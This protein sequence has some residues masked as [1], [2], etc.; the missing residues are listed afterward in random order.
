MECREE[1]MKIGE[2]AQLLS[3]KLISFF[4]QG[5]FEYIDMPTL[6][7]ASDFLLVCS[8]RKSKGNMVQ[9][10][11]LRFDCPVLKVNPKIINNK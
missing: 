2:L 11:T 6:Q 7:A 3:C 5:K 10:P 9:M 8:K 1:D 4:D